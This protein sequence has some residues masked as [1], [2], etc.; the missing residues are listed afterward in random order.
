MTSNKKLIT[1]PRV[2]NIA[3]KGIAITKP[4]EKNLKQSAKLEKSIISE[5]Y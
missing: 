3:V 2:K 1:Y 5:T 4:E